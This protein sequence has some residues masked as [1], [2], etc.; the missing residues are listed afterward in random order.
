M[1]DNSRNSY[2]PIATLLSAQAVSNQPNSLFAAVTSACQDCFGF[3]FLTVLKNLDDGRHIQR[4]HSSELD[5]PIGALKPMGGTAWGQLVLDRGQCWI[6]NG[7][8]D[9]IWAFPD[10]DLILSK[11]CKA[12]ACAPVLWNGRTL[13]VLSLNGEKDQYSDT[14]M[15]Q[16]QAIAQ[17]LAPALIVEL[18]PDFY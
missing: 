4:L 17:T 14:D 3:R 8:E 13:G 7:A 5:Y 9:I 1:H 18:N 6:G 16:M 12:C 10:A 15:S 11:G 2:D